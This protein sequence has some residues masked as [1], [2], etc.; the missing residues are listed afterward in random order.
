MLSSSCMLSLVDKLG[1]MPNWPLRELPPPT[2]EELERF[3]SGV[4]HCS[5]EPE[6]KNWFFFDIVSSIEWA[7]TFP[8]LHKLKRRDQVRV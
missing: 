8:V 5:R 2:Q 4:H 3:R 6:R 1:P 7:K